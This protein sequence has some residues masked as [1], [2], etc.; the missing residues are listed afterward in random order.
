MTG[1]KHLLRQWLARPCLAGC[2]SEWH[3][4]K[5]KNGS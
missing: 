5:N 3:K 1:G 4:D 2:R